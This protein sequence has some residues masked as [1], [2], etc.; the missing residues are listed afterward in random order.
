MILLIVGL[1]IPVN[2]HL[3]IWLETLSAAQNRSLFYPVVA[4]ACT[5]ILFAI[6]RENIHLKS[7]SNLGRLFVHLGRISYGFMSI[8]SFLYI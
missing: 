6:V 3:F 5:L 7:Q 8:M 1:S 2:S 4:F